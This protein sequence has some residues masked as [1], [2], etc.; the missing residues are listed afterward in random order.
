MNDDGSVPKDNPFV[1]YPGARPTI[2][3]MGHRNPQGLKIDK[4][5]R[6]IWEHEHGPRGG[7]ELNIIEKAKNYGWPVISYGINYDGKIITPL[8]A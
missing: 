3:S 2:W 5:A 8:T 6:I 4:E 7:D 1:K